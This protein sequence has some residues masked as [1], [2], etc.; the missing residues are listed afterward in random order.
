MG[1]RAEVAA[2]DGY[3]SISINRYPIFSTQEESNA[4]AIQLIN[5]EFTCTSFSKT[6]VARLIPEMANTVKTTCRIS[7]PSY[8][9]YFSGFITI[10]LE[11]APDTVQQEQIKLIFSSL[12]T[13]IYFKDVIPTQRTT[14][15]KTP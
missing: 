12:A 10:F 2:R 1:Q 7:I 15:G 4:E 6:P 9:G 8:Y 5:G 14:A 3:L 11:T 13:H